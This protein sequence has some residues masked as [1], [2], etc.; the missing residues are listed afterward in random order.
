MRNHYELLA[1]YVMPH[2]QGT[3]ERPMRSEARAVAERV[4]NNQGE[5]DA[6]AEAIRAAGGDV[7]D[8]ILGAPIKR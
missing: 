1:R 6:I 2:F 5:A 7:P 4:V 3:Y 8:V